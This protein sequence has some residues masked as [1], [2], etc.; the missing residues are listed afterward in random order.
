MNSP[1][2]TYQRVEERLGKGKPVFLVVKNDDVPTFNLCVQQF[3]I[4]PD[5]PRCILHRLPSKRGPAYVNFYVS[6]QDFYTRLSQSRVSSTD[7][8]VDWTATARVYD[9][10]GV[11]QPHEVL[12]YPRRLSTK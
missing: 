4:D 1:A 11:M 7:D 12:W 10:A 2:D 3:M 8:P 6:I 9:L 5:E